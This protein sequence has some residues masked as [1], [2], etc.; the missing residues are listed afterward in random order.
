MISPFYLG[1]QSIDPVKVRTEWEEETLTCP[2]PCFV[3]QAGGGIAGKAV[4]NRT[5]RVQPGK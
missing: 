1:E 3:S 2:E 5:Y 4:C